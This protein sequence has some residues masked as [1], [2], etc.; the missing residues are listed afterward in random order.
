MKN[1]LGLAV[2][3][4]AILGLAFL[5]AFAGNIVFSYYGLSLS[6]FLGWSGGNVTDKELG[7]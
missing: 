7:R 6:A 1:R 5:H 4:M 2:L 3:S